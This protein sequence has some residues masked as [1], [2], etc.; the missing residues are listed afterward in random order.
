MVSHHRDGEIISRVLKLLGFTITR[1]STTSGGIKACLMMTRAIKKYDLAITPDG[2][3]GPRYH[4][5]GGAITIAKLSGRPLLPV[6]IGAGFAKYFSSWDRFM[7]PLP[8]SRVN[9]VFGKVHFIKQKTE[10]N[11]IKDYFANELNELNRVAE[12]F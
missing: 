11:S 10:E 7:L 4:F 12:S 3:K 1:G 5:S 8:T 6:G 2:P 9:I